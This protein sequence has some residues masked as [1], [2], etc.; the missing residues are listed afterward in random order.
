MV[1][2]NEAVNSGKHSDKK[3]ERAVCRRC[4]DYPEVGVGLGSHF[5]R[6]CGEDEG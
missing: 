5:Y 2:G 4:W 3:Q 6:R 1:D